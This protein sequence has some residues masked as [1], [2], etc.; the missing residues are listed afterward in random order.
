MSIITDI[1]YFKEK[2]KQLNFKTFDD[3]NKMQEFLNR[4]FKSEDVLNS[5]IIE[6]LTQVE[7]KIEWLKTQSYYD[8]ERNYI[9][10]FYNSIKDI[11][12]SSL[13]QLEDLSK[14]VD[15]LVNQTEELYDQVLRMV[16]RHKESST[17]LDTI[18]YIQND[19]KNI[20]TNEEKI[21]I[22]LFKK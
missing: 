7:D 6:R 15:Q 16:H 17:L 12:V 21:N 13:S 4:V 8:N 10:T 11:S 20:L 18:N 22:Q 1:T 9:L 3:D 5:L 19:K 2:F 14:K